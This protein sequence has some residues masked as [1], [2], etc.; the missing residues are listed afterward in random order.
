MHGYWSPNGKLQ[1][2][3][4]ANM[5]KPTSGIFSGHLDF[6]MLVV[7]GG[8]LDE[9]PKLQLDNILNKRCYQKRETFWLSQLFNFDDCTVLEELMLVQFDL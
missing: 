3:S 5:K 7:Y 1:I 2:F 9:K 8:Q 4:L 6:T